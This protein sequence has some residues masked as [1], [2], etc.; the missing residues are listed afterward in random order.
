M[1]RVLSA[2]PASSQR[3]VRSCSVFSCARL[4]LVLRARRFNCVYA[5]ATKTPREAP[6]AVVERGGSNWRCDLSFGANY[7]RNTQLG[8]IFT[9]IGRSRVKNKKALARA[10][11]QKHARPR[12]QKVEIRTQSTICQYITI[13]LNIISADEA[14]RD[15]FPASARYYCGSAATTTAVV[16]TRGARPAPPEGVTVPAAPSAAASPARRG[17]GR[18]PGAYHLIPEAAACQRRPTSSAATHCRPAGSAA[19][20]ARGPRQ[21]QQRSSPTTPTTSPG[22]CPPYRSAPAAPP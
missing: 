21:Q 3:A 9:G 10:P 20:S 16:A 8:S 6:P 7:E 15:F 5:S 22:N 18:A 19:S 11:L 14:A 13:N 4:A 1:R 12:A 17:P 2:L